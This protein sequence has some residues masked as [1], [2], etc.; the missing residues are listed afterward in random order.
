MKQGVSWSLF[1]QMVSA[2]R[3]YFQQVRNC[4]W[5]VRH[6]PFQRKEKK[7]P[8]VLT[9]EEIQRLIEASRRNPR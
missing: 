1:N 2:L 6:I 3:F 8:T 4:D 7:L 5:P 9:R